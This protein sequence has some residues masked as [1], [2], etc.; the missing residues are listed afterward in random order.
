MACSCV[1]KTRCILVDGTC[2]WMMRRNVCIRDSARRSV[3][4]RLKPLAADARS[5]M[6]NLREAINGYRT[7]LM[8]EGHEGKRNSL[9]EV[10]RCCSLHACCQ[11]ICICQ[12]ACLLQHYT[13]AL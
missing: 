6:Q 10:L 9:L 3:S 11:T 5:A 2:V 12:S 1:R 8:R 7:R 4:T 13:A